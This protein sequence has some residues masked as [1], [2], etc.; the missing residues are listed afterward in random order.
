LT[1][2]FDRDRVL[3][4]RRSKDRKVHPGLVNGLGG[5]IEAS[6]ESIQSAASREVHEE[7]GLSLLDLTF[8]GTI[9]FQR[10]YSNGRPENRGAIYLFTSNKFKGVASDECPE[11]VLFWHPLDR[12]KEESLT[13]EL[14]AYWDR[15]VEHPTRPIHIFSEFRDDA[16]TRLIVG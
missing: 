15:L 3:L 1:F 16:P 2:V 8:R 14:R 12:V 13:Q 6:D 4:L 11:G 10:S 7:S 5:R 9:V